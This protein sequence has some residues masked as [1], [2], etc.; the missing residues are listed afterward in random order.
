MRFV[1]RADDVRDGAPIGCEVYVAHQFERPE[2]LQSQATLLADHL[3]LL[4]IMPPIEHTAM[5]SQRIG[6]DGYCGGQA[7]RGTLRLLA[8]T[9]G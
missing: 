5:V 3:P 4:V 9:R 8:S 1:I 6:A 7:C 2:I